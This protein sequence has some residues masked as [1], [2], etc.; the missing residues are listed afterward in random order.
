MLRTRGQS[1]RETVVEM[2]SNVAEREVSS[3]QSLEGV[4]PDDAA[5]SG[6]FAELGMKYGIDIPYG[7]I[8]RMHPIE[9]MMVADDL[10]D[11]HE[12]KEYATVQRVI[13]YVEA[14][15]RKREARERTL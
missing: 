14:E 1:I 7:D 6:F 15:V 12:R 9:L 10:P 5:V 13:D 2:L 3:G 8:G 11:S 4:F